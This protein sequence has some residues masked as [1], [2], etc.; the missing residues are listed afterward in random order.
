M[1]TGYLRAVVNVGSPRTDQQHQSLP[2]PN[3]A[4]LGG[5][6]NPNPGVLSLRLRIQALH[7]DYNNHDARHLATHPTH[8]HNNKKPPQDVRSL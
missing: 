1:S 3:P 5:R 6:E 7:T 4:W 8:P 2:K